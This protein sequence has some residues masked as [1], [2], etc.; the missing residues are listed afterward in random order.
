M[1]TTALDTNVI[2]R[3][4]LKDDPEQYEIAIR[5]LETAERITVCSIVLCEVYWVLTQTIRM[6]RI[7]AVKLIR[8]FIDEIGIDCDRDTFRAGAALAL[9]G[10]DF[11]DGVIAFE[12]ARSGATCLFTFDRGF[13]RRADP[14]VC[15][16]E[17]LE[18]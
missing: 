2:L 5:A 18:A 10:G 8:E 6:R 3:V 11:A 1:K 16:V 12:A 13:A 14:A 17:L 15:R 7:E 4:L 9:A